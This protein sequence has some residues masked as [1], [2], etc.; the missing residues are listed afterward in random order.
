MWA[1]AQFY[2]RTNHN[3]NNDPVVARAGSTTTSQY[4]I[5]G[6]SETQSEA[7]KSVANSSMVSQL[8]GV[9]GGGV[10]SKA[11]RPV[12][13]QTGLP[14]KLPKLSGDQWTQGFTYKGVFFKLLPYEDSLYVREEI[15]ALKYAN[16]ELLDL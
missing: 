11:N 5:N 10:S 1:V 13:S 12:I 3:V 2:F 7:S 15:K 16:I 6:Q 9:N 14:I 8:T 4:T